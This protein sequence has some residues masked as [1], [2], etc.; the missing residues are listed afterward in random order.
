MIARRLLLLVPVLV[1]VSFLTYALTALIPGDAAQTLA[2]GPDAQPEDIEKVRAELHLDEP[3][4]EQYGSWLGGVVQG[5]LGTSLYSGQPIT[6]EIAERLPVTFSLALVALGLALPIA[7]LVGIR[8]GLRPGGSFDRSSLVGTSVA[9]AMPSFWVGLLLV[10]VFAVTLKWLPPFG[11]VQFTEDPWQWFRHL[12][13][14]AISLGLVVA[15]VLSRQLRAG[16]SDTMDS[17]FVRTGWAKGGNTR[18]VVTGHAL[19]TSAIPAVTVLG[20]QIGAL[21]GGAVIIEQIFSLP[22][23]G[24][25]L[26]GAVQQQD[27]PVVLAAALLLVVINMLASLC[28]DIT[29]GYLNPKV[30]TQ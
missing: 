7:L 25:Y 28:V 11:Y 8:G 27:I 10:S 29:Y 18:R 3:F 21:L 30:R 19:K 2:G 23:L 17:A 14:P 15:A 9:I 16:L 6:D 5:D 1:I 24:K 22:G 26:L 12:I 4:L 20:L 13:L